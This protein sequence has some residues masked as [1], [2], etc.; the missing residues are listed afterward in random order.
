MLS[1]FIEN[2]R[3][4]NAAV[5]TIA[6]PTPPYLKVSNA[7]TPQKLNDHYMPKKEL[8]QAL[9]VYNNECL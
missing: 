9:N 7:Y 6:C 8:A 5:C 4:V 2:F 1:V 3:G